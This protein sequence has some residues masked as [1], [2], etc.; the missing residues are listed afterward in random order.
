ML[1]NAYGCTYAQ[2]QYVASASSSSVTLILFYI[3]VICLGILIASA[4]AFSTIAQIDLFD[5]DIPGDT[6]S[7]EDRDRFR[8]VAGYVLSASIV[9]IVTQL[10][11]AAHR[12]FYYCKVMQ[13]PFYMLKVLVSFNTWLH[14]K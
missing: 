11:L 9:G 1:F 7:G 6:D 13:P 3:Q 12:G 8:A 4:V 5:D 2:L 10:L 14:I